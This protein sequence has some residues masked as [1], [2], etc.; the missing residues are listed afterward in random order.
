MSNA[1]LASD[2]KTRLE[3]GE[4]SGDGNHVLIPT[5][6]F[7]RSLLTGPLVTSAVFPTR[8]HTGEIH[9][10]QNVAQ[11]F[12]ALACST[13]FHK[14]YYR[15]CCSRRLLSIMILFLFN[16]AY[17]LERRSY[18]TLWNSQFLS[19]LCPCY[20]IE[21][22][23]YAVFQLSISEQYISQASD[24]PLQLQWIRGG[25]FWL[26]KTGLILMILN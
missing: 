26:L 1:C 5:R 10:T 13:P 14:G 24:T 23:S 19:S 16:R 7:F 17:Q 25:G 22:S 3:T 12:V 6:T 21:L 18:F 11:K 4:K 15:S 9:A 20:M 8:M 2:L